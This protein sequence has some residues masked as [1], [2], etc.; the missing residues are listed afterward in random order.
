VSTGDNQRSTA[1]AAEYQ[2]W[3]KHGGVINLAS[4]TKLLFS[5]SDRVRFLN[6]QVTANI[7]R[8]DGSRVLPACVTTAKGKLCGD[9]FVSIGPSAI[10][11]DAD[12]SIADS[13][14]TRFERYIVADDVV[15]EVVS[16]TVAIV[17]TIG[18]SPD[19]LTEISGL[20]PLPANRYGLPGFDLFPPFRKDLPPIWEKLTAVFPVMSEA[21]IETIRVERGVPRW[22]FELDE[23]TLPAEAGLD[24]THVD[25]HKGCYIGQEVISR[26]ESVGRVNRQLIGFLGRE[27]AW[28][29]PRGEL[30]ARASPSEPCGVITSVAW[31]FALERPVALG[32]LRRSAADG[33]LFVRSTI[34]DATEIPVT[35]SSLPFKI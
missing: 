22:G 5:G 23:N 19:R 28:L 9:V 14:P 11:V 7:A 18:I 20:K 31:S 32:Y 3:R 30:F 35:A 24:V 10:L 12:A 34:A 16:D 8:A 1:L 21:L 26:I 33:D 6:G 17:H 2:S 15:L 4:R 13:L 25:F 27:S 29:P